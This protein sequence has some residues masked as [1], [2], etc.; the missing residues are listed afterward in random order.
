VDQTLCTPV[1]SNGVLLLWFEAKDGNPSVS[2]SYPKRNVVSAATTAKVAAAS[3]SFTRSPRIEFPF[4]ARQ[5]GM[6]GSA[7]LLIAVN[8]EGEIV[9][10]ECCIPSQTKCLVTL[11]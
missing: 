4:S 11:H 3:R 1:A 7:T 8:H 10:K 6:E 5:A 2:V 9:Q